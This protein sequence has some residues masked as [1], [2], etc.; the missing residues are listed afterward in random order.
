MK[1]IYVCSKYR[2]DTETNIKNA[3]LYCRE[4]VLS[5][6]LPIAPHI[7]FTQFLNDE[8]DKERN[9]AFEINKKLILDCDELWVFGNELSQGMKTEID[10]STKNK[11]KIIYKNY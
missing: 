5:G 7:Y 1:K 11:I 9:I 8:N 2:G 10:F 3:K 4:I 6:N